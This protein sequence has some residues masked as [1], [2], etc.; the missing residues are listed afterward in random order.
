MNLY[1]PLIDFMYNKNVKHFLNLLRQMNSNKNKNPKYCLP[2]KMWICLV[3][4]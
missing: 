1:Y 4:N 2:S 3:K